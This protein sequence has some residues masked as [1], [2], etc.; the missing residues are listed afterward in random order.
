VLLAYLKIGT[1][2]LGVHQLYLTAEA[3]VMG[4][5][6]LD[7]HFGPPQDVVQLLNQKVVSKSVI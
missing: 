1:Y 4:L 6:A 7:P 3:T 2:L 5:L